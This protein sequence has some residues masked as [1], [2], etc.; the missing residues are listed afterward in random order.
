MDLMLLDLQIEGGTMQMLDE[1]IGILGIRLISGLQRGK[2][3]LINLKGRVHDKDRI[4]I[5]RT[6]KQ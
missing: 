3:K 2:V 6:K 4:G 5:Q 1:L